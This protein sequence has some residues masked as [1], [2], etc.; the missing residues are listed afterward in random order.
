MKT[1]FI[2]IMLLF[3]TMGYCAD[4]VQIATTRDANDKWIN[5]IDQTVTWD[6]IVYTT[7]RGDSNPV[8]T[9]AIQT[10]AFPILGTNAWLKAIFT[11][12]IIGHYGIRWTR[13]GDLP[14]TQRLYSEAETH[15]IQAPAKPSHGK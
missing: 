7:P 12:S 14:D 13:D 8:S 10:W 15:I 9:T 6:S 2:V 5:W 3:A 4:I 11:R 1:L